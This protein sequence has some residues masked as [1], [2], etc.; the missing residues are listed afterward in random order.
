MQNFLNTPEGLL[1]GVDAQVSLE[2]GRT[3]EVLLADGALE[4]VLCR[5]DAPVRLQGTRLTEALV[6]VFAPERFFSRRDAAST[7]LPPIVTV[8]RVRIGFIFLRGEKKEREKG[9]K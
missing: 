7:C 2:V 4:R 6:A 9:K 1:S 5:V 8:F 3:A